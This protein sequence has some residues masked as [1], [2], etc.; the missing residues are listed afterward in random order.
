MKSKKINSRIFLL[1]F[2]LLVLSIVLIFH[3]TYLQI[4]K[5]K[6][7]TKLSNNNFFKTRYV[8]APRG[9]ILDREGQLI[10]GNSLKFRLILMIQ[11]QNMI[12]DLL[13]NIEE[14]FQVSSQQVR[15][16]MHKNYFSVIK[17][18]DNLN[19]LNEWKYNNII[20]N[21][22][23]LEEFWHRHNIY[24]AFNH[25]T[26]YMQYE[27]TLVGEKPL[28]GLE[29]AC[30]KTL[31]GKRV[32]HRIFMDTHRNIIN[33]VK[34]SE[35]EAGEDLLTTLFVKGQLFAE[36]LF[37]NYKGGMVVMNSKGE[38]LV[39]FSSPLLRVYDSTPPSNN[40]FLNKTM[41]EQYPPASIFKII[42]AITL[43]QAPKEEEAVFCTGSILIGHR[44]WHCWKREGHGPVKDLKTAMKY[45]CNVFFYKNCC[46][47]EEFASNFMNNLKELGFNEKTQNLLTEE[48][49]AKMKCPKSRTQMMMMSIGQGGAHSTI[50]QNCKMITSVMTGKKVIPT[51]IKSNEIFDE[52]SIHESILA[53]VQSYIKSTFEKGGN[54][55]RYENG[56]MFGKTGTAQVMSLRGQNYKKE[57]SVFAGGDESS[58]LYVSVLVENA[59]F[60]VTT[61]AKFGVEMLK[62][63]KNHLK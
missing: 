5:H 32:E 53:K 15:S 4:F 45:S 19:E 48:I 30:N 40:Y 3:L 14:T 23:L 18:F 63:I 31:E 59:G 55:E 16:K 58:Q 7:F 33:N 28:K 39:N 51:F 41:Q 9:N 25:I 62:Y 22:V 57:H 2:I 61:A 60:G 38:I 10:V 27:C 20:D 17:T 42:S 56:S 35:Y 24:N 34:L 52:L 37:N 47:L 44:K 50:M 13:H 46:K 12:Q 36:E 54:C 29:K 1:M 43:L 49:T 11:K 8:Y 26:G 6:E 21:N